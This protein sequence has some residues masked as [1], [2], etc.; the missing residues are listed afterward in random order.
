[1]DYDKQFKCT[2]YNKH[3]YYWWEVSR[4]YSTSGTSCAAATLAKKEHLFANPEKQG[5]PETY[6]RSL[7]LGDEGYNEA[8]RPVII[9]Y[10][11]YFDGGMSGVVFQEMREAR[12]L[13]YA[14]YARYA[15]G[16]RIGEQNQMLA[17]VLCQADKTPEAVEAFIS[18]IDNLPI[19]EERFDIAREAI[20]N[21]YKTSRIGFREVIGAVRTWEYQG[22]EVD[23]RI[24]RYQKILQSDI[25][26]LQDFH[27][28]N[29]TNRKKLISIVGSKSKIDM[30][31]L[32]K[33]GKVTEV[34]LDQ[35][36]AF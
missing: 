22:L 17:I 27:R 33:Y 29:I 15:A 23:P 1:M 20:I 13:A 21:R 28:S 36:F 11:E 6:T 3:L 2:K 9:L 5:Q 7:E 8:K 32:A 10:N 26:I 14:S 18:L 35:I 24:K 12:A 31:A 34:S 19:S 25:G 16:S 4:R 30:E